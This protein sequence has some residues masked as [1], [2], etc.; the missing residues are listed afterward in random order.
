MRRGII[1]TIKAGLVLADLVIAT[2]HTQ[3][4]VLILLS[5]FRTKVRIRQNLSL[6]EY[7]VATGYVRLDQ[8]AKRHIQDTLYLEY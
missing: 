8:E 6:L 2:K 7:L 1:A 4:A 3:K 5:T